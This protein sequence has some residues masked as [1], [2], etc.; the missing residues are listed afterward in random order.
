MGDCKPKIGLKPHHLADEEE[1][2]KEWRESWKK[3]LEFWECKILVLVIVPSKISTIIISWFINSMFGLILPNK[4]STVI[5]YC[6]PFFF[7][8]MFIRRKLQK[9]KFIW[10]IYCI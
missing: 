3:G 1:R 6:S 7:F 9:L 5:V 2:R 8:T 4:C 10:Q